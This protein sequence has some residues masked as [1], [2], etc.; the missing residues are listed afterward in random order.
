[1]DFK[2]RM[3]MCVEWGRLADIVCED[4]TKMHWEG[5]VS[6][7]M[8]RYKNDLSCRAVR[9]YLSARRWYDYTATLSGSDFGFRP[10]F[11]PLTPDV[12]KNGTV[13]PIA[14]L[15]MSGKPVLVPQNPVNG[16]DIQQYRKGAK[17]EFRKPLDDPR[18]QIQAIKVDRIYIADRNLLCEISW[19]RL[20]HQGFGD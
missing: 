18:Y 20:A 6:W 12:T 14:T 11:V 15:Y 8:D 2:V 13:I 7:C 9:G 3:P 17:L 19:E 16:G 5:M 4:N 1:M 10:A